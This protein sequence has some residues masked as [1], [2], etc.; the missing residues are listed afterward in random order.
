[1]NKQ[2]LIHIIE[3]VSAR[4]NVP[5][6]ELCGRGQKGHR[7]SSARRAIATI[8]QDKYGFKPNSNHCMGL[9]GLADLLGMARSSLH[10]AA[11]KWEQNEGSQNS[12]EEDKARARG[13]L[14]TKIK[15]SVASMVQRIQAKTMEDEIPQLRRECV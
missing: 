3:D 8:A 7:I 4:R 1:M 2:D 12:V 15:E 9:Q 10:A 13:Y 5:I 14:P 6:E 11:R